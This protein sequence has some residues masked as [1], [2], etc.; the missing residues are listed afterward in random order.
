MGISI[1]DNRML[2]R[3]LEGLEKSAEN[4][5]NLLESA[6]AEY[7]ST[8]ELLEMRGRC[9]EK[10]RLFAKLHKVVLLTGAGSPVWIVGG[11]VCATLGLEF[12]AM[13]SLLLFPI[14]FLLFVAGGLFLRNHF[15]SKG[16]MEHISHLIEWELSRRR[17]E[18]ERKRS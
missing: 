18:F 13:F 4:D 7:F 5:F 16:Y 17:D 14:S 11:F 8:A 9:R 2:N 6:G 12:A 3:Y 1:M 15:R 10:R